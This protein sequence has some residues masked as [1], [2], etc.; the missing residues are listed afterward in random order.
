[1]ELLTNNLRIA[2]SFSPLNNQ[3]DDNERSEPR[4]VISGSSEVEIRS[5][6][7]TLNELDND[8]V[9]EQEQLRSTPGQ[10]MCEMPAQ[11][12]TIPLK[13]E[14]VKKVTCIGAGFVGGMKRMIDF[15]TS[16]LK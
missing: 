8:D 11:L 15:L 6:R 13:V 3:L 4:L 14:Q 7:T 5:S 16:L 10:C 1:M 9:S 12:E 2:E